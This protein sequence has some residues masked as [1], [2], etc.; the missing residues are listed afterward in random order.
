M[1]QFLFMLLLTMPLAA[2][3]DF[4]RRPSAVDRPD[5]LA[6]PPPPPVQTGEVKN[7]NS[8]QNPLEK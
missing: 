6:A 5:A 2:C 3:E 7:G 1:R 4:I 8:S